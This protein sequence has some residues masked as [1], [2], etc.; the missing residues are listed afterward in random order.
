MDFILLDTSPLLVIYVSP[1]LSLSEILVSFI[2]QNPYLDYINFTYFFLYRFC[3]LYLQKSFP[4]PKSETYY[5]VFSSSLHQV[6]MC[7]DCVCVSYK[8][9]IYCF[10]QTDIQ[11]PLPY[12]F[13]SHPFY[14]N[15]KCYLHHT[16]FLYMKMSYIH[17]V[18]PGLYSI[19][20]ICFSA[21][22]T[23]FLT[24][25]VLKYILIRV[26]QNSLLIFL[27]IFLV[28]WTICLSL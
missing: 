27:K 7:G 24:T 8:V 17:D 9:Q 21:S 28:F 6:F 19:L 15:L 20:L 13:H 2:I 10:P 23:L 1:I 5:S 18:I 25:M 22:T 16:K 4:S 12:L 11:F 14:A 26:C 3:T